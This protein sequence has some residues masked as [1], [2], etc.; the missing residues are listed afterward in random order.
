MSIATLKRIHDSTQLLQQLIDATAVIDTD[1]NVRGAI[2][3]RVEPLL[4]AMPP[5]TMLSGATL[6]S[7]DLTE[8]E[9]AYIVARQWALSDSRLGG[10][11]QASQLANFSKALRQALDCA[12]TTYPFALPTWLRSSEVAAAGVD[13][14]GRSMTLPFWSIPWTGHSQH[15]RQTNYWESSLVAFSHIVALESRL[16][17]GRG[18]EPWETVPIPAPA[19]QLMVT[20]LAKA[21]TRGTVELLFSKL[22]EQWRIYPAEGEGVDL[23]QAPTSLLSA[24]DYVMSDPG[25]ESSI[26]AAIDK[27]RAE[28]GTH[29]L[30]LVGP[31]LA[32]IAANVRDVLKKRV[33]IAAVKQ[34]LELW[35]ANDLPG[36]AGKINHGALNV[37]AGSVV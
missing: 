16:S 22:G 31:V 18:P 36:I 28:H 14:S 9:A 34:I 25:Q 32:E 11:L 35:R 8:T 7:L 37:L 15:A 30:A 6:S 33:D 4:S 21:P 19:N 27:R 13:A 23:D 20:V 5:G 29:N 2:E 3:A 17:P 24:C 1:S 26:A 12:E 10:S